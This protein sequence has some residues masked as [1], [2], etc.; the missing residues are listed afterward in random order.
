MSKINVRS[1]YYIN[2]SASRL[3]QVD[4]ELYVYTGTQTTS[5]NNLFVLTSCIG[6]GLHHRAGFIGLFHAG[7]FGPPGLCR[8][9]CRRG[10]W[11]A[12]IDRGVSARRIKGGLAQKRGAPAPPFCMLADN[13][14]TAS[15]G[16]ISSARPARSGGGAQHPGHRPGAGCAHGSICWPGAYLG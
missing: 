11:P 13:R 6:A 1:P 7:L 14:V 9:F 2:I 12:A 3:T 15:S 4:M 16:C 5:R 8:D 10:P